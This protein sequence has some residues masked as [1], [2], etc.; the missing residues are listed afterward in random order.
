MTRRTSRYSQS[1]GSKFSRGEGI[2]LWTHP[3]TVTEQR[4]RV[5]PLTEKRG[6]CH[7]IKGTSSKAVG[8][9]N[10]AIAAPSFQD[11]GVLL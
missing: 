6:A 8:K 11:R 7:G 5:L 3:R 1:L 4:Q 9:G 2:K 10:R